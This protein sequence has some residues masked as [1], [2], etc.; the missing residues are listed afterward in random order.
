MC[1][2]QIIL[3]NTRCF[4]YANTLHDIFRE[5]T[6]PH[7]FI[8]QFRQFYITVHNHFSQKTPTKQLLEYKSQ[9]ENTFSRGKSEQMNNYSKLTD[10]TE[11]IK[12]HWLLPPLRYL[13][14]K[15]ISGSLKPSSL[16]LKTYVGTFFR[17]DTT[18]LE[19]IGFNLTSIF[20]I[21]SVSLLTF[22]QNT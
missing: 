4:Y 15:L 20:K 11:D 16:H 12:S 21:L 7:F 2:L 6:R 3:A 22:F 13:V 19:H 17:Y 8:L 18:K 14:C 1:V 5:L 9:T 10:K